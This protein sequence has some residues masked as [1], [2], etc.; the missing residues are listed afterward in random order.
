[1]PGPEPAGDG[2]LKEQKTAA[3]RRIILTALERHDWHITNT[4][5]ALGLAD[6][7][8]LLKIMRRHG[9]KR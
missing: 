7:S 3:E 6:H 1:V 5:A 8:S 9:L 4:A 2:T